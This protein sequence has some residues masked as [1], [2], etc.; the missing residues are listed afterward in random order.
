MLYQLL[1]NTETGRILAARATATPRDDLVLG[2]DQAVAF[3]DV[4]F[5]DR[6][7]ASF[8]LDRGTGA[9]VTRE[10]WIP[11]EADVRLELTVT[12]VGRSPIDG[13]PELPAD[14]T[15]EAT[16]TVQKRALDSDRALSGAAHDNLLTIRTT[17]GTLSERQIPLRRGRAEFK[18]RSSSETVV[19]E[20]RVSADR[21]AQDVSARIEFAPV[22]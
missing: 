16:I 20:V 8:Q 9:V 4:D 22:Q 18:L 6:P 5:D 3:T 17:A 1:Y 19:A 21:I 15:S 14:G 11:P 10:E 13:T 7:L 2:P 12:A